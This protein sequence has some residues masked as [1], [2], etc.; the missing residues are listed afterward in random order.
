MY[1]SKSRH[2]VGREVILVKFL[3]QYNSLFLFETVCFKKQL[4]RKIFYNYSPVV[5]ILAFSYNFWRFL[6]K[7][8]SKSGNTMK[9]GNLGIL[10][11]ST[12]LPDDSNS[13]SPKI[14]QKRQN[15]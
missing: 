3:H 1:L 6:R 7:S 14:G 11:I 2:G 10:A 9:S 15:Q 4:R 12:A 8:T 5:Q 13:K